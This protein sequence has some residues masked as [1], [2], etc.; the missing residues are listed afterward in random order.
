[1]RKHLVKILVFLLMAV[2]V[3]MAVFGFHELTLGRLSMQLHDTYY[4]TEV[5][6]IFLIIFI[7]LGF[8][9]YF[10]S[11]LV[12]R[13][14]D[15]QANTVLLAFTLL[16]LFVLL[17]YNRNTGEFFG[18]D[19]GW[20]VYPPK[21]DFKTQVLPKLKRWWNLVL[22]AKILISAFAAFLI[23]RSFFQGKFKKAQ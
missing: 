3:L 4:V 22:A 1:M 6:P 5:W 16:L 19:A 9:S 8:T 18:E 23:Y 15:K 17:F 11:E 14:N 10:S 2:A 20:V 12:A 13:F 21:M 7:V